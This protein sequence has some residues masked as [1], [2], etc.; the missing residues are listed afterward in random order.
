M[1]Y[2]Q[3]LGKCQPVVIMDEPQEGMDTEAAV[4][5]LATLNPLAKLRYSA[6]HKVVKNLLFR[7][8]PADAYQQGIVKKIE[9]LSVAE[10]NDEATLKIELA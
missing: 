9:V 7:L 2:L 1:T 4:A 8:T 6:T 3:A 10:R 5:R